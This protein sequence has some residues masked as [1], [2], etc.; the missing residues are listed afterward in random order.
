MKKIKRNLTF[1]DWSGGASS[2][3]HISERHVELFQSN[4]GLILNDKYGT[5]EAVF[6]RKFSDDADSI[7]E[8]ID[9]LRAELRK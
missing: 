9:V 4:S 3:A 6:A 8:K 7:V 1:T 5:G 2:P